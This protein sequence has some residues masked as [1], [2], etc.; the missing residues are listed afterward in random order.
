M[1]FPLRGTQGI[2]IPRS[3]TV[4]YCCVLLSRGSFPLGSCTFLDR[5]FFRGRFLGGPFGISLGRD[6]PIDPIQ[7]GPRI[8]QLMDTFLLGQRPQQLQMCE[9][10][11]DE[12]AG[13][14][15]FALQETRQEVRHDG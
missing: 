1:A 12:R 7:E 11:E 15:G 14:D 3:N 5:G 10:C 2:R 13:V 4:D 9:Y 8:Q 6:Q